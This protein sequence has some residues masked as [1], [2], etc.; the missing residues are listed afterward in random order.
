MSKST[1]ESVTVKKSVT[2]TETSVTQPAP[3]E[4]YWIGCI[5]FSE[6]FGQEFLQKLNNLAPITTI[7][8]KKYQIKAEHLAIDAI[9]LQAK[10]KYHLIIDRSS[11]IYPQISGLLTGYAFQ[12]V[13]LINNPF[14]FAYYLNNKEATYT[15]AQELGINIPKTYVLPPKEV[16]TLS[17][18]DYRFHQNIDWGKITDDLGLPLMIK[19]S[20]GKEISGIDKA[21]SADELSHYHEYSGSRVMLLQSQVKNPHDWQIYCLCIG[22]KILPIK[23]IFQQNAAGQYITETDFL[24]PE[25][26]K[27]VIN[28][29]QVLNRVLG[30]E[31]NAVEL[32]LDESGNLQVIDFNHPVPEGAKAILGETL[33]LEY[34]Q[35][36]IDLILDIVQ[37]EKIL[38]FVPS[39][40]NDFVAIARQPDVTKAEKFAQALALAKPYYQPKK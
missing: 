28:I 22:R 2:A 15:I 33:Y 7:N 17:P 30:Y 10:P 26:E 40:I 34:Q 21:Q 32:M 11:Y 31:M 35:A 4:D 5:H 1:Q 27:Q 39:Q 13:Y 38:D 23:Y 3:V 16:R 20:A 25:L 24:S 14:C 18:D 12:G 37:G 19:P 9:A 36:L 29:C 8:G 6:K